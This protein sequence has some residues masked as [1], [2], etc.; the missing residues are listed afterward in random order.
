MEKFTVTLTRSIIGSTK[1]QKLTV[2]AL[3]L[4]KVGSK[5]EHS[6]SESIL[7][8]INKV[9]HLVSIETTTK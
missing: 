8:M 7:G 6:K 4:G 1:R 9:K 5:A 3:G 2:Q